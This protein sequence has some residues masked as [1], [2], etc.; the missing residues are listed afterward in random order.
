MKEKARKENS[1]GGLITRDG[2]ILLVEVRNLQGEILWTFPK[3]H[4]EFRETPRD[5][6]LREV[7]EETGWAC[8]IR[9]AVGVVRY[10]FNRG[11]RRVRK[12]VRWYWMEPKEL[13]GRPDP[14]EIRRSRWLSFDAAKAVF[15]YP[16]DFRLLEK[17]RRLAGGRDG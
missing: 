3:G 8:A 7:L 17:V 16:G 11:Q 9:R 6:A 4:I 5:A 14:E 12:R 2:K 1:A 15:R 10:S 13:V